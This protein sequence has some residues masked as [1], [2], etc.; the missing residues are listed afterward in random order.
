MCFY[1]LCYSSAAITGRGPHSTVTL[2]QTASVPNKGKK[3]LVSKRLWQL[4][5]QSIVNSHWDAPGGNF[6]YLVTLTFEIWPWPLN[7]SQMSFHL[8][9]MSK[10]LFGRESEPD[11]ITEWQTMSKLLI[12]PL[13]PPGVM[14]Q[15]DYGEW[16][17]MFTP[18]LLSG[19]ETWYKIHVVNIEIHEMAWH[20]DNIL[21]TCDN[22]EPHLSAPDNL[23]W[24]NVSTILLT[25][26]KPQNQCD[27]FPVPCI[28]RSV[29]ST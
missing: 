17:V 11:K 27:T 22:M 14:K 5:Q 13:L 12:N 3:N 10:C 29:G 28:P 8:T 9:Y 21:I 7:L 1:F 18:C 23:S 25:K 19:H 6:F 26:H 4:Y 20:F 24:Q 15:L 2:W 16:F